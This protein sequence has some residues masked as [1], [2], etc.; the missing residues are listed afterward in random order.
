MSLLLCKEIHCLLYIAHAML[1][2]K[3]PLKTALSQ[4]LK[5]IWA[6]IWQN[7]QS[8]CTPSEDSDLTVQSVG[9]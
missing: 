6:A 1:I 3:A 2:W 5:S 8:D 7:Q 9:S 4:T